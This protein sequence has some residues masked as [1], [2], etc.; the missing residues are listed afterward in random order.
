MDLEDVSMST[1]MS[2]A[3]SVPI[4]SKFAPNIQFVVKIYTFRFLY[5]VKP[6]L[7]NLKVC[8]AIL[9]FERCSEKGD[10]KFPMERV[11]TLKDSESFEGKRGEWKPW[12]WTTLK[13][14]K[15]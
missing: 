12:Q 8:I 5:N 6:S 7:V 9:E 2:V 14:P 13:I 3:N 4:L 11:W 15:R 10:L 1:K